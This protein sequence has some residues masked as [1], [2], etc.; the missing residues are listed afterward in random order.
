[1]RLTGPPGVG[2]TMLAQRMP[3]LLPDLGQQ[4]A[5]ETSA[6][7]SVAGLLGADSPMMRRPPFVDPHHSSRAV[8]I[9]GGGTRFVRPGAMSLAHH[10]VLFL[11]EAPE[12]NRNVLNALRQPLESGHV[13]ISRAAQTAEFPARFQL[14]LAAN[15]CPCGM[16]TLRSSQCGCTPKATREYA[17]KL[18]RPVL[19]RIDIHRSVN[20]ASL[21]SIDR[22]VERP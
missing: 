2:K 4:Q 12:F 3:A 9:V 1:L 6:I 21:A 15:P 18:S 7:Y 13:T 10:G 17:A 11:D 16:G 8:S 14:V 19:D 20:R 22:S 5:M